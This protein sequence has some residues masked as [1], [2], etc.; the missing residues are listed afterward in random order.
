MLEIPNFSS[1]H[2]LRGVQCVST[3]TTLHPSWRPGTAPRARDLGTIPGA[4]PRGRGLGRG[5]PGK[6]LGYCTT[7]AGQA[8]GTIHGHGTMV[9]IQYAITVHKTDVFVITMMLKPLLWELSPTRGPNTILQKQ[10]H[11]WKKNH[12]LS[13]NV[14]TC[15]NNYMKHKR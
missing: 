2:R 9:V 3:S 11:L 7:D 6:V 5:D 14:D 13:M 12:S 10:L 4:V 1:A 15:C 8:R